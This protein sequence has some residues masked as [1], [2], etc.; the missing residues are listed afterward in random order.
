MAAILS[1]FECIFQAYSLCVCVCVWEREREWDK[2]MVNFVL[3]MFFTL[4]WF[5][6]Q[7]LVPF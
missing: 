3:N 2:N 4:Y 7:E 1:L 5:L 6:E